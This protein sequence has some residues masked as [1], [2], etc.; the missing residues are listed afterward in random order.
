MPEGRGGFRPGLGR[1]THSVRHVSPK[2]P[3]LP[4]VGSG[5]GAVARRHFL[6]MYPRVPS[7]CPVRNCRGSVSSTRHIAH[8]G[9]ISRTTRSCTLCIKVY[10]TYPFGTLAAND[11]TYDTRNSEKS[12]NVRYSYSRLH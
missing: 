11:G 12:P 8:S 7:S 9:R 4:L 5:T 10:E 2:S 1:L 6:A 3:T